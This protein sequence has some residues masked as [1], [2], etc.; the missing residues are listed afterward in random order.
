MLSVVL[1][2]AFLQGC[3]S[4]IAKDGRIKHE[5]YE[6]EVSGL[7]WIEI[8]YYPSEA[9]T[10]IPHT[11][12]LSIYG[13]GEIVFRTGKSPRLT[14][15]FS[16]DTE[17]PDWN[18]YFSDRMH[19]STKEIQEIYKYFI[20]EG[21]VAKNPVA[22]S[23]QVSGNPSIRVAANIGRRKINMFTDNKYLVELTEEALENFSHVIR[24]SSATGNKD[25]L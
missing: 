25:F 14:N 6:I 20:D 5:Q 7:D 1:A 18:H 19:M 10:E 8:A 17:H 22:V 16:S 13:S 11:C 3:A 24:Q 9:N 2:V 12:F 21:I 15:S 23:K 4:P